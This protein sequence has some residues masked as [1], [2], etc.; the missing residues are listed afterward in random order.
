MKINE[1]KKPI[2]PKKYDE[3]LEREH[4]YKELSWNGWRGALGIDSVII[5]YDALLSC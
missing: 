1:V 2:F 3:I 5:A 4:A